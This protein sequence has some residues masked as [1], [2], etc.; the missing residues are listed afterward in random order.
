M[1]VCGSRFLQVEAGL[2]LSYQIEKLEVFYFKS[3]LNGWFTNM[4]TRYSVKCTRGLELFCHSFLATVVSH[5][6][7]LVSIVIFRCV[8]VVPKPVLRVIAS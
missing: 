7:W 2:F 6:S 8:S 5:V 3:L 1:A 4:P